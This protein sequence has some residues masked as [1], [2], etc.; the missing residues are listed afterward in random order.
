MA[1]EFILFIT[2]DLRPYLGVIELGLAELERQ[3]Q[4]PF[5]QLPAV[6]LGSKP[7]FARIT[8]SPQ[9]EALLAKI[10]NPKQMEQEVLQAALVLAK[11]ERDALKGYYELF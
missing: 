6:S 3:I 11:K 10:K 1:R 2:D 9:G 4:A 7:H 8:L 5:F